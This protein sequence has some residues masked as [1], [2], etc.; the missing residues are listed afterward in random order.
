MIKFKL[1]L[2]LIVLLVAGAP[3]LF[4]WVWN[5]AMVPT[6]SVANPIDN[7]WVAFVFSMFF[8]GMFSASATSKS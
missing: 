1:I 8:G 6:I 2:A 5:F 7:Y 3:F 4:M